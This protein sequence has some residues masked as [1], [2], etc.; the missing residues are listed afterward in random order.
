MKKASS[1]FDSNQRDQI[2]EAVQQAE[3]NTTCE[4]VPVVAS[5]SGRY[6]RAEDI[7]GLWLAIITAVVLWLLFPYQP[8]PNGWDYIPAYVGVIALVLSTTV[9]FMIGALLAS[10]V[11]WLRRLFTPRQQMIEETAS[12]ARQIFFDQRIHHTESGNGVM[13]YLSMF[14]HQAVVLSDEKALKALTQEQLNQIC[15]TLTSKLKTETP[16]DALLAA[17]EL[18]GQLLANAFPKTDD[19]QNELEDAL[20]L[21]D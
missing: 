21:I 15:S 13:I 1:W 16:T 9:T 4:I 7:V 20:V 2:L 18:T 5:S 6:D 14:E 8:S 12:R 10:Q 17:I 3:S 19:V 11:G